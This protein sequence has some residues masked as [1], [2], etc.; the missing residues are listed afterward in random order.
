MA[1]SI[2]SD[3]PEHSARSVPPSDKQSQSVASVRTESPDRPVETAKT[4]SSAESSSEDSEFTNDKHS[5]RSEAARKPDNRGQHSGDEA[6]TLK[7]RGDTPDGAAELT[8]STRSV[9]SESTSRKSS[10]HSAVDSR[11]S[12]QNDATPMVDDAVAPPDDSGQQTVKPSQAETTPE[13][14][15]GHMYAAVGEDTEDD[16]TTESP[17]GHSTA[18]DT[19]AAPIADDTVAPPVSSGQPSEKSSETEMEEEK[20]PAASKMD[21]TATDEHTL[22][23]EVAEEM[24]KVLQEQEQKG[25]L[26]TQC[27]YIFI[28]LN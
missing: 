22:H 8:S 7:V 19:D 28:K 4:D 15:P 16:T 3:T 2:Q 21:G 23:T 9:D 1:E 11:K 17:S 13:D 10:V 25:R 20:D 18:K 24:Q 14:A 6:E 5:Q 26:S 27:S 12:S